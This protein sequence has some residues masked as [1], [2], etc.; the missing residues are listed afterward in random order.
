MCAETVCQVTDR[1]VADVSAPEVDKDGLDEVVRVLAD[2]SA[3]EIVAVANY[4]GV[5]RGR[6]VARD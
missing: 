2:A 4:L 3:E 1:V 5:P 6:L